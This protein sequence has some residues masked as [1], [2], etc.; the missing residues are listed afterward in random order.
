MSVLANIAEGS[1]RR[2]SNDYAHFL[3]IA[4]SSVA[5]IECLVTICE[6]L[7]SSRPT[8]LSRSSSMPTDLQECLRRCA[9]KCCA[10]RGRC[11]PRTLDP[12]R[13]TLDLPSVRR[14]A[15]P[16]RPL[17]QRIDL[18]GADD[19][20]RPRRAQGGRGRRRCRGRS[21]RRAP[22]RERR[23]QPARSRRRRIPRRRRRGRPRRS[24]RGPRRGAR[25]GAGRSWPGPRLSGRSTK[26]TSSTRPLRI[27]SGGSS[28]TELAVA[29]RKTRAARSCIQVSSVADQALGDAAVGLGACA[30]RRKPSRSRRSRGRTGPCARRV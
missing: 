5:E 21:G 7:D 1:K 14:H 2:Y 16:L 30:P 18:L 26:K 13:S 29:T 23:R 10:P 25:G 17:P 8:G 20:E 3:N 28:S 22:R 9:Q 12:R 27:I 11:G 4:E 6:D 15:P 19:R 24:A